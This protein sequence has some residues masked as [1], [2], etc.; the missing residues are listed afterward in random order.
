MGPSFGAAGL[1]FEEI[2]WT[3]D[4]GPAKVE[5]F[6]SLGNDTP[7]YGPTQVRG[8]RVL[9][10]YRKVQTMNVLRTAGYYLKSILEMTVN[11]KN[12]LSLWPIFLMQRPGK[13][14][15]VQLRRPPL[16]IKVRGRMD[17]WSVKETFL[18]QF[19]T[20]YGEAIK[21]GW[22]IVDVGAGVGD[23]SLYA[24]YGRPEAVVYAL[25][26]FEESYHLFIEN[27]T[28]NAVVNVFAFQRALW[29]ESGDLVLELSGGEPL[30]ISSQGL[31]QTLDI[32]GL[33]VVQAL[34]LHDF[35]KSEH[36]DRVDLMKMDCEGA[37]YEILMQAPQEAHEKID[38]VIMEY[39]D[40]N[41]MKNH[42]VLAAFFEELGYQVRVVENEVH[43]NIGYLYAVRIS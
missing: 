36:I 35:L 43:A 29:G 16:Q 38:R 25:E 42:Q 21:D 23:F 3:L 18:D 7:I 30:Q 40:L 19:Y 14:R 24:G 4:T 5:P 39:H 34:S 27:L 11:F 9:I 31:G 6:Y 15:M 10:L 2:V 33:D 37:E 28:L 20:R 22:T 8:R 17:V 12:M 1:S 13:I 26:P 41:D 32:T